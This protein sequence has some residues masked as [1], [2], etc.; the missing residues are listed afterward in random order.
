[1][2]VCTK[3]HQ[4]CASDAVHYWTR[5]NPDMVVQRVSDGPGVTWLLEPDLFLDPPIAGRLGWAV[6]TPPGVRGLVTQA[7]RMEA[8]TKA[9]PG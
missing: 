8:N 9:L 5:H 6:L 3:S 4:S 2:R 1:M 7:R